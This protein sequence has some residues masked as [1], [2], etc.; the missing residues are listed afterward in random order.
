MSY[1][2]ELVKK[3]IEIFDRYY[4]RE[5]SL[6]V[7]IGN[8]KG[9]IMHGRSP[10]DLFDA[11][12]PDSERLATL[13]EVAQARTMAYKYLLDNVPSIRNLMQDI[14][15]YGTID[16]ALVKAARD[17]LL[18]V[19]DENPLIFNVWKVRLTTSTSMVR[20]RDP[21]GDEYIFFCDDNPFEDNS[22]LAGALQGRMSD[23]GIEFDSS[24]LA[25]L[26]R[27]SYARVLYKD[28]INVRGGNFNGQ[29][30]LRHPVFRAAFDNPLLFAN[31][32]LAMQVLN[33]ADFYNQG[34]H[35]GWLPREMQGGFGRFIA[36][37]YKGEAFYP[38]NNSTLGHSGLVVPKSF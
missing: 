36:L 23:G 5:Q 12:N 17:D 35:S 6:E 30:W 4:D 18:N 22:R 26:I 16:N 15:L 14:L 34:L 2:E 33:L 21:S 1:L 28:Y 31:Y 8:F 27:E 25:K 38:P 9:R 10:N 3:P 29:E 37:G 20:A 13:R 24:A 19:I 11:Y 7:D 32:I